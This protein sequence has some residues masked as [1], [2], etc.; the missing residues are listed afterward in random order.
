MVALR[1]SA[2]LIGVAERERS[3]GAA[4]AAAA[5]A[6]LPVLLVLAGLDWLA[7]SR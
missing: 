7:R 3:C 5:G 6:R 2:F 4:A 1:D